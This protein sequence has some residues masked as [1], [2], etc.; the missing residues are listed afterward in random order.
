MSRRGRVRGEGTIYQRGDGRWVARVETGARDGR[1]RPVY[2]YAKTERAALD[3][4][5]QMQ[6]SRDDGALP[7]GR[8]LTVEQWMRHYLDNIARRTLADTTMDG[9]RS[10]TEQHIIPHLGRIRLDRLDAE[11]IESFYTDL[12]DRLAPRTVLQIHHILSR[13]LKIAVQRK[14][15]GVNPCAMVEAPSTTRYEG[16]SLTDTEA[17]RVLDVAS[18][19]RS[20]VRWQIGLSMGLRQGE[21]LGLRWQYVDLERKRLRVA[22]VY[23][24]PRYRHGCDDPKTCGLDYKPKARASKCPHRRGGPMLK[25]PKSE[26]SR[27]TLPLPEPLVEV[28]R[29]HR[30]RQ[31]EERIA[32]G[33]R[34]T[35]WT[36]DGE[37]VDDLVFAQPNG[38]PTGPHTD[39]DEWKQILHDAGVRDIRV[40]DG[41]HTTATLLLEAGIDIRVVSEWLGHSSIQLTGDTYQHVTERLEREAADRISAS[42][43]MPVDGRSDTRVDTPTPGNRRS[44]AEREPGENVADLRKRT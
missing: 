21:V 25:E 7:T 28:L 37:L 40:H 13:A 19:L 43:L 18:Q 26:K 22:L 33:D 10:K 1:R 38:R 15:L 24:T 17:R 3:K 44:S 14:R 16:T 20:A 35:G 2:R 6:R 9:H 23:S 30:Q 27:R 4:L 36:Y 11:R 29:A 31:L 32:L 5:R 39:W 41:R 34:W 8:G 12:E 42:I